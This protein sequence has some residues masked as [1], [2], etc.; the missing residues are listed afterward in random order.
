MSLLGARLAS[1]YTPEK[2]HITVP[3]I[4]RRMTPDAGGG[5]A[6]DRLPPSKG[7]LPPPAV[8]TIFI[9]PMVTVQNPKLPVPA[10]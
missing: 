4:Y 10:R 6:S 9:P 5:G 1:R 7:A 8:R 3:L 2:V